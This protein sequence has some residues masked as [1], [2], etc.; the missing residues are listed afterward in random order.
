MNTHSDISKR[1]GLPLSIHTHFRRPAVRHIC[2]HMGCICLFSA[3]LLSGLLYDGNSKRSDTLSPTMHSQLTKEQSLTGLSI[4]PAC[5]G[6]CGL[7]CVAHSG[8]TTDTVYERLRQA[9]AC[10]KAAIEKLLD[11]VWHTAQRINHDE[12]MLNS[13]CDLLTIEMEISGS[14][15]EAGS[16]AVFEDYKRTLN[17][18]YI[19]NY[20]RFHDILFVSADK[21]I[22]HSIRKESDYHSII[23]PDSRLAVGL[24]ACLQSEAHTVTLDY[25]MYSPSQRPSAFFLVPVIIDGNHLGWFVLQYTI[26]NLDSLMVEHGELGETGE[27]YLVNKHNL[28]LT[29]SRFDGDN[30][31]LRYKVVGLGKNYPDDGSAGQGLITDYRGVRVYCSYEPINVWGKQWMLV[32]QIDEAEVITNDYRQRPARCRQAIV[33]GLQRVP[34]VDRPRRPSGGKSFIVGL[35]EFVKSDG[36]TIL[37]T[38]GIRTCTGIVVTYPGRFAYLAHIS[39][40]DM[41]YGKERLTN[42]YKQMINHIRHYDIP[43][44]ELDQLQV[45]IIAPHHESLERLLDKSL[46]YGIM[47]DQVRFAYN[48]GADYANVIVHADGKQITIEWINK[49]HPERNTIQ[50]AEDIQDFA[51]VMRD[52]KL[53]T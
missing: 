51:G 53:P 27:I 14:P 40:Y 38:H 8:P 7:K 16:L 47:L 19:L 17:R 42:I 36:R 3:G 25:E 18:Y 15:P 44:N 48:S 34:L 1:N 41:I 39:S 20:M 31:H 33:D 30:T 50:W 29:D 49:D 22:F 26:K 24:D 4:D 5:S 45:L 32:A 13:F 35:D 28:M 21:Y 9:R 37:K 2:R 6:S 12:I 10:K 46:R 23:A 43:Q 52:M 11:D